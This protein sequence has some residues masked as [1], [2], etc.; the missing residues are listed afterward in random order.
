MNTSAT[1][2]SSMVRQAGSPLSYP[3]HFTELPKRK[4]GLSKRELETLNWLADGQKSEV[5]AQILNI[6][7]ET[8][9]THRRNIIHKLG[10]NNITAAVAK[11]MRSGLIF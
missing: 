8:V 10:V 1:A 11:A 2:Q 6:S 7:K 4:P 5:V 3:Q 9:D